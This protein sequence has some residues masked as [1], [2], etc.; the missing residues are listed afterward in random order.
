MPSGYVLVVEDDQE[1]RDFVALVL[2]AEGYT[3]RT[4]CN[5]VEALDMV[6][7]SRPRLI[8]LDMRMPVMDGRTFVQA[9]RQQAGPHAPVLVL[10][11]A[12]DPQQAAREVQ[13]DGYLAKP[14]DL[15]HL[16]TLARRFTAPS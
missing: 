9:Y 10:T 2:E 3:V 16:L 13:A 12:P 4:A 14:F 7:D 5:G 6:H 15:D 11:A 1:I 8:L